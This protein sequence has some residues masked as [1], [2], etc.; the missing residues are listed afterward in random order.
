MGILNSVWLKGGHCVLAGGFV[1]YLMGFTTTF[2]DI[3]LFVPQYEIDWLL[4]E[5][6][7]FDVC[8]LPVCTSVLTYYESRADIVSVMSVYN[9]STGMTKTKIQLIVLA[10]PDS[11]KKESLEQFVYYVLSKFDFNI[12]RVALHQK[13]FFSTHGGLNIFR[14]YT[15]LG[16]E[17]CRSIMILERRVVQTTRTYDRLLKY[18]HRINYHYFDCFEKSVCRY[19]PEELEDILSCSKF[20]FDSPCD[21]TLVEYNDNSYGGCLRTVHDILVIFTV[22]QVRLLLL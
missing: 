7:R 5:I 22:N 4:E 1:S 6:C 13:R 12:C 15:K 14:E 10:S 2:S 20:C 17:T 8:S 3:D 18:I 11:F 9:I 16:A 19:L 21:E